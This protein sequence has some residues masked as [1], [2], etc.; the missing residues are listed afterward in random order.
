MATSRL[1]TSFYPW[2]FSFPPWSHAPGQKLQAFYAHPSVIQ[3]GVSPV[4]EEALYETSI[5]GCEKAA[6][7][8]LTLPLARLLGQDVAAVSTI[9][10]NPTALSDL[11]A[12]SGSPVCL[13]LGH[14]LDSNVVIATQT[15]CKERDARHN[16]RAS[17]LVG[18]GGIEPPTPSTSRKCSPTELR[19]FKSKCTL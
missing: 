3:V 17:R 10:L 9:V 15:G 5:T 19:A 16:W 8:K 11:E 14:S 18:T 1:K 7:A 12:L 4:R 6:R 2:H 13:H